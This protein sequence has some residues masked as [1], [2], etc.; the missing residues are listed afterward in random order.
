VCASVI[1]VIYVIYIYICS[2]IIITYL[3]NHLKW[4]YVKSI[5]YLIFIVL[6]CILITSKFFSPTNAPFY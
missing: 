4:Y 6:P 1:Y 2:Y 3:N 5:S